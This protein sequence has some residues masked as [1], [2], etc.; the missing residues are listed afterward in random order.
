MT[1]RLLCGTAV[2]LTAGALAWS[3]DQ[4]GEEPAL[5]GVTITQAEIESGAVPLKKIRLDGLRVFCM[6]FN[7]LDGLGDG[8][9]DPVDRSSPGGRPTLQGN[10]RVRLPVPQPTSRTVSPS[11]TPKKSMKGP[12]SRRL[13]RPMSCS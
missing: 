2:V 5:A 13:Q 1:P 12:A 9:V 6:P 4:P 7:T 3:Q 10:G 8:P 11:C